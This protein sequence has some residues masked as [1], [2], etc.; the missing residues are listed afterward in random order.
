MAAK[1]LHIGQTVT[2]IKIE[3]DSSMQYKERV[4]RR[5]KSIY[6]LLGGYNEVARSVDLEVFEKIK[7][8]FD[9]AVLELQN[10]IK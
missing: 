10:L 4:T 7:E 3:H 6:A 1:K 5:M 2:T 9:D 8:R